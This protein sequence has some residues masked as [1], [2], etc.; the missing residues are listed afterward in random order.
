[1]MIKMTIKAV[2]AHLERAFQGVEISKD[3][4][5]AIV[6]HL[7]KAERRGNKTHGIRL[8]TSMLDK[9]GENE[10]ARKIIKRES[11]FLLL[12]GTGTLGIAAITHLHQIA[13]QEIKSGGALIASVNN[14]VGSSGCLGVYG[15]EL[16]KKGFVSIS[17]CHSVAAVAAHGG[18]KPILGT[19]PICIAVPGKDFPFVADIATASSSFG[20]VKQAIREK[21]PIKSGIVQTARGEVTYD[22]NEISDGSILPMAGHKGYALGLAIELIC[23]AV[24]GGKLG[25][26]ARKGRSSFV[27]IIMPIDIAQD[28]KNISV[29]SNALFNEI[30]S[31]AISTNHEVRI[32]GCR[33]EKRYLNSDFLELDEDTLE[34]LHNF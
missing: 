11:G 27:S 34:T 8:L 33:S 32:P 29:W 6:Q 13:L 24:I 28:P 16:A 30:L 19:N 25:N 17:F 2:T 1:M 23:G 31:S 4:Q 18:K 21:Q 9:I 7:I 20:A 14:Y 15:A 22:P 3:D 12:D 26:E 5:T 10:G